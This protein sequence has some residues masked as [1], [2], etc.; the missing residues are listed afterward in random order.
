MKQIENQRKVCSK[1][2]EFGKMIEEKRSQ[3]KVCKL[4]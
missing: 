2:Q 1:S 3:E 4:Q